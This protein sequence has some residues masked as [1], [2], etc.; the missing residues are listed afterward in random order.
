MKQGE[1]AQQILKRVFGYDDFRGNQEEV[2]RNVVSGNN[3]FVLMPTGGGKSLCYQIPA[4]MLAGVAI[5]VSPLIALMQDQVMA[6]RQLGVEAVMLNSSLSAREAMLAQE[7]I[8]SGQADIVYIAPE[9]LLSESSLAL[10]QQTKISLIA[11]DEAHC[12]SSWGHDFRP[13]YTRI[14]EFAEHF[15]KVPR[16]ALT[17]TADK[18]TRR[19][20]ITRLGLGDAEIFVA[21]FDRPNISYAIVERNN[22]KQQLLTFIKENHLQDSGIVYC[23]SRKKTDETAA[24][25]REEGFHALPYHAGM[26]AKQRAH[27]QDRFLKE[28]NIIMVATIAFGMG[29]D[30]PNVR[31][32]AHLN[33][34]K[35]IESYYQETGRA[36]RDG[37]PANAWMVYGLNDVV[38][39]RRWIEESQASDEQKRIEQQKLNSLLGLC[40]ASTCLRQILL[41]YFGDKIDACGN[42]ANCLNPP[43]T[44]VATI[45]AQKAI[46]VAY[47]TGQRFGVNYLI[48]V[49]L[50]V[51]NERIK[52]WNHHTLKIYGGGSELKRN[53]WQGVFRQLVAMA[54]LE[55]DITEYGGLHITAKGMDFL[56]E[57]QELRLR[58]LVKKVKKQI[59]EKAELVNLDGEEQELYESLKAKRLEL[60]KAQN[61]PPYVIFHDKT[62]NQMAN[63]R[64]SNKAELALISGVGEVKI[65]K[66]GEAFLEIILAA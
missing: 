29:I 2:I 65:E 5:V 60:A 34:P 19:D 11:I 30:K 61:V 27:N 23:I 62:L 58:R 9:R 50:G 49:L 10:F 25:L 55:V 33:I 37:L 3:V 38:M 56:K 12:V 59:K 28:E 39:L 32:V 1:S 20:I 43:E 48:D 64:P 54:L 21:N 7:M 36:G 63:I 17:A 16:I 15:P 24:W 31:F 42:C 18:P 14:T 46:S 51:E 13:E 45:V 41:N 44:F 40:E 6:L 52:S 26:G 35:N 66:Y 53:D 4:L 47:R 22:P 8:K 57:K